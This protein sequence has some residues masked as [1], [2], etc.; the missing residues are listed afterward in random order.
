MKKIFG[1]VF[2]CLLALGFAAGAVGQASA[3]DLCVNQDGVTCPYSTIGAAITAAAPGDVI[4][5]AAGTYVEKIVI[6]KPLT[7]SG[8]GMGQSI[9]DASSFTTLGNVIEI[10]ALI[11]NTKIKGFDIVTGDWNNGIRSAGGTDAAGKIEIL[12]NHIISTYSSLSGEQFGIIAGYMDVRKL[13]ISGNRISNTYSNSIL[14]ELQMGDTDITSNTLEGGFPSIWFMTYDGHDVSA[15]QRVSGN[16]IDMSGSELGSN[17]AGI[18]VNP[19]TS[20]VAAPNRTGKYLNFEISNNTITGIPNDNFIKGISVGEDSADGS[21]GAFTTL[22]IFGNHI[23]GTG[24]KGI[25]LFSH[26]TGANIHDNVLTGL[27]QGMR[28]FTTTTYYPESNNIYDN[29]ISGS[30]SYSINYEG[31]V[32][33]DLSRN[34]WGTTN[35]AIIPTKDRKSVV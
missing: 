22:N 16:T 18:G 9:I 26:I 30:F 12:N 10:T 15:L 11:G 33:V 17:V 3:A 8:A 2:A 27:Y 14:V 6:D 21:G 35:L 24:G 25:Q 13:N 32:P 29:Q 20:Y 1:F 19:S 4:D 28:L 31:T 5:V 23:S 7:L 34:W